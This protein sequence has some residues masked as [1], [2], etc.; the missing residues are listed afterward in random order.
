MSLLQTKRY[1]LGDICV[2]VSFNYDYIAIHCKEYETDSDPD[3]KLYI[4]EED[5]EKE[6]EKCTDNFSKG[7]LED[8]AFYR[9]FCDNVAHEGVILMHGCAVATGGKAYIFTAPSGTGKTTHASLWLEV[10]GDNAFVLN[11]DK[12]L[13]R[14][15]N[16]QFYVYGTPWNGK[17]NLGVNQSLPL[18]AIMKIERS[19]INEIEKLQYDEPLKVLMSQVYKPFEPD[20]MQSVLNETLKL[21]HTV[22]FY[23]LS[24][25]I[26]KEA[27]LLSYKTLTK[28]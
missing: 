1:L 6:A 24:C 26:S 12:P 16:G 23:K 18:G 14:E 21:S 5:I 9:K 15:K 17:E 4:S 3:L 22:P 7:Y 11:G 2:E 20:A 13:L 27:A 8:L 19:E 25:N 10:L 28:E